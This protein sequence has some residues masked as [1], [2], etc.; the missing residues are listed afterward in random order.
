MA[1]AMPGIQVDAICYNCV[2][3]VAEAEL[4]R[5]YSVFIVVMDADKSGGFMQGGE[6]QDFGDTDNLLQFFQNDAAIES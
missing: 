3:R 4:A 6:M 1:D 5:F 2:C